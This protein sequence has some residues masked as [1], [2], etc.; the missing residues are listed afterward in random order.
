MTGGIIQQ[1]DEFREYYTGLSKKRANYLD[2]LELL[3]ESLNRLEKLCESINDELED[4]ESE[5]VYVT[6]FYRLFGGILDD[7]MNLLYYGPFFPDEK[8]KNDFKEISDYLLGNKD[9]NGECKHGFWTPLK[10]KLGD[11][12]EVCGLIRNL[13][14]VYFT[15]RNPSAHTSLPTA[16]DE[17]SENDFKNLKSFMKQMADMIDDLVKGDLA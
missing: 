8:K 6:E 7:A 1:S 10:A 4:G 13:R 14:R 9:E 2:I 5:S 17:F 11:S 15:K 16:I 12:E 3:V